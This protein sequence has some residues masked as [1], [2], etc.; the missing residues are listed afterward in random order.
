MHEL[1]MVHTL[2]PPPLVLHI[3][4]ICIVGVCLNHPAFFPYAAPFPSL[5]VQQ[6]HCNYAP[7]T[8]ENFMALCRSGYY[9]DVVFHRSIRNFMVRHTHDPPLPACRLH[10]ARALM[11]RI[12]P[13]NARGNA[14]V[15]RLQVQVQLCFVLLVAARRLACRSRAG[16]LQAL[17][18]AASHS[19][20]PH[21]RTSFTPSWCA[22]AV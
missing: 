20:E 19:G 12:T 15:S 11:E 2:P 1:R 21:S 10:H 9:N 5:C 14:G 7:K 18:P 6:L 16:I 3:H 17:G 22:A 4:G 13:E 8:C